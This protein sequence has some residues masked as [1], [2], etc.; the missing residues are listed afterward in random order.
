MDSDYFE[1]PG[2]GRH[3]RQ[4]NGWFVHM[5]PCCES[6]DWVVLKIAETDTAVLPTQ[7]NC[8]ALAGFHLVTKEG[9]MLSQP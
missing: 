7:S 9:Q 1:V 6:E 3:D 4:P 2:V 5:K 8:L